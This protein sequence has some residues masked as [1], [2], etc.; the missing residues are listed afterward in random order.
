VVS[1]NEQ[2]R[3][4]VRGLYVGDDAECFEKAAEL[5]LQVNFVLMDREI[6]KAVVYLDPLEFKSTWLGNKAVYRTRMALA[7]GGELVVIAPGVQEFGEDPA[8][9]KLIRKYGYVG[10]PA[11]L[12]A[13]KNN[14]DLAG[15]LSAAAHLIHGSSEGRFT[16]T[17]APGGLTRAEVEGVNFRYAD[18]KETLARYNPDKLSDGYNDVDGE[19]V[20]YISNPALGLWAYRGRLA[21]AAAGD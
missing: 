8:I 12:E 16:I 5:S 9:D 1:K 14:A 7:T 20:F 13:V 15:N 10:T 3:L 17:Y 19:E 21:E 4:V 18:L 6:R 11:V 2:G